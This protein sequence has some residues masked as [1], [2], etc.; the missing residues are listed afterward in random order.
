[1]DKIL[2]HLDWSLA[3]TFLAVAETGSLSGAARQLGTSQPT[4]GRQIKAIEVQLGAELFHRQPRGFALTQIGAELV[5]P[6]KAMQ[7]AMRQ[8]ALTA[9]GQQARL[10]G[11]VRITASVATSAMHLPPIIAR[12]RKLEP[13]IA[14]ELVPS[15]DT[16]NLL[17][18]EADIAVRMYRPTQLDLVTQHIGDIA[19]GVFAARSYLAERGTPASLAD[20][21]GHDFVGFDKHLHII[22]GMARAGIQVDRGFYKVRCD[23]HIAYWELVRAGC[24]IGFAQTNI[25]QADPLVVQ[26]MKDVAIPPLPIWLTAHAAMR[27]TPRIRRVWELLAEGLRPLVS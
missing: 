27:Q 23:D 1:M 11:T 8:I 5:A 15:D 9:A 6:A 17:F 18:R 19:L 12:I 21:A 25:G 24:G 20:A 14:I 3:Q 10:D 22:E 13:Q 2:G 26:L 7:D 16:S 4:L